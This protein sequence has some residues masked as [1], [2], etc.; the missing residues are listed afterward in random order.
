MQRVGRIAVHRAQAIAE[1]RQP[2]TKRDLRAFLGS[3]G[4]YRR[5]IPKFTDYSAL[6]TPATLAKALGNVRWSQEMLGAFHHLRKS[7]C[8][9]CVLTVPCLSDV[10]QLH[11]DASGIGIGSVLNVV[12]DGAQYSV[13]FYSR[14]LKGAKH[15]YSA[16]ELEA[17]AVVESIKHFAHFLFGASFTVLTDHRLTS[18]LTSNRRLQGMALK[19]MQYDV[20]IQYRE[21]SRNENAD[22]LSRQSWESL[23]SEEMEHPVMEDDEIDEADTEE[24][25]V[26]DPDDAEIAAFLPGTG[27]HEG[28]CGAT[29]RTV[30]EIPGGGAGCT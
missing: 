14:Q 18:L 30:A 19:I 15:R 1:F 13:A 11:T 26:V 28:G 27:L 12:R 3:V 10:F 22:G 17:L 21:G 8:N 16:I 20:C 2:T 29:H 6:L 7:L 9:Y 23:E 5:F 4:Y 24:D 25:S